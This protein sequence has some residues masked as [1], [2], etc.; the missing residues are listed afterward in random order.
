MI[1]EQMSATQAVSNIL[2]DPY[3]HIQLRNVTSSSHAC[4]K[5]FTNG[6][7]MGTVL[8]SSDGTPLTNPQTSND[9][10][11]PNEGLLMSSGNPDDFC[12]ND[13]DQQSTQFTNETT[14]LGYD[15]GGDV[16][17]T[18]IAKKNNVN[19]VTYDACIIEFGTYCV[20][21][22]TYMFVSFVSLHLI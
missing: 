7:S 18:N 1:T 19:G 3:G 9:Y 16:D 17:L 15:V 10:L 2:R 5:T 6:Y 11:L 4:Y 22:Y 20:L 13:S 21:C 12:M 8:S 14:G